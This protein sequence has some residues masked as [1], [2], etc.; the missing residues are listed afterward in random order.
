MPKKPKTHEQL[1]RKKN[2]TNHAVESKH[3]LSS[4]AWKALR[5]LVLSENP[6]CS[7]C[8]AY[9]TTVD[10]KIPRSQLDRSLWLEKSNCVSMCAGCHSMKT[11]REI[12]G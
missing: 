10:H 4:K 6:I 2:P 12:H 8:N 7:I 3:F 1:S 11:W 5:L 9:A